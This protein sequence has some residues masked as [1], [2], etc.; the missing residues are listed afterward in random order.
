MITPVL[1]PKLG[2][3]TSEDVTVVKWLKSDGDPVE[4]GEPVVVIETAKVTYE[5]EAQASGI[6]FKLKKVGDKA[7]IGDSLGIVA[8]SREE[9]EAY[10]DTLA[11]EPEVKAPE[12]TASLLFEQEE[13][14]K[15]GIRL[16][17]EEEDE[18][19]PAASNIEVEDRVVLKRI[20]FI[21]MRR[22]IANNLG[23]S[24]RTGAQLTVVTEA[25]MTEIANS[26]K[27]LLPEG[28]GEKVPFVDMLGLDPDGRPRFVPNCIYGDPEI[29]SIG[30]TD[31]AAR[32]DGLRVK[33]GEF[34]FV[35]NGRAGTMGKE[36]GLILIVSDEDTDAVLGVHILGPR[37]TELISLGTLTMI[38]GLTVEDLKKT[39]LPHLTFSESFFEA[40]LASSGEGRSI[41]FPI[42]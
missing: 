3:S 38:T 8:D 35:G 15:E 28:L 14:E 26:R 12:V 17:F 23:A 31:Y 24:L 27:E 40:A 32:K 9:F 19:P 29:G 39:V 25:D 4:K 37:A 41:C 36:E 5:V 11:K 16:S 13:G 33:T 1:V 22:T 20:P 21:G 18:G 7:K 10:R 34:Y 2:I 6:V 42:A 30:V